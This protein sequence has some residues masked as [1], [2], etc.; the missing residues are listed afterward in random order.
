MF[1]WYRL[2]VCHEEHRLTSGVKWIDSTWFSVIRVRS[3]MK[4]V[5]IL[6]R[7]MTIPW[8]QSNHSM[9]SGDWVLKMETGESQTARIESRHPNTPYQLSKQKSISEVQDYSASKIWV[10]ENIMVSFV[11]GLP[12][13]VRVKLVYVTSHKR[14][15]NNAADTFSTPVKCCFDEH[16]RSSSPCS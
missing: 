5:L 12:L 9:P 7:A 4:A 1:N 11:K 8:N 16:L 6:S 3:S 13:C 10:G 2:K 15:K 14:S